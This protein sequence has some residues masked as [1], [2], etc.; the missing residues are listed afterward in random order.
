MKDFIKTIMAFCE[1]IG[2]AR[3]ATTLTRQG[4]IEEARRVM[5]S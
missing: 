1:S 5:L 3:A 4:K 2:R